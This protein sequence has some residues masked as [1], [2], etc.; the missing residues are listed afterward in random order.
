MLR[1]RHI[2]TH[3]NQFFIYFNETYQESITNNIKRICK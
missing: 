1:E 3:I 2:H